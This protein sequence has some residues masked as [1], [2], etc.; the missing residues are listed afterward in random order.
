M[1]HPVGIESQGEHDVAHADVATG[2]E[3][4]ASGAKRSGVDV[5]LDGTQPGDVPNMNRVHVLPTPQYERKVGSTGQGAVDLQVCEQGLHL[6]F[7]VVE[8][9][10]RSGS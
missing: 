4:S 8:P 3:G 7:H 6:L 10:L 1:I 5:G 9:E 2:V